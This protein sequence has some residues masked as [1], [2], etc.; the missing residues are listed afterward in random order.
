LS[1]LRVLIANEAGGGRGHVTMLG[2]AAR[3][4]GNSVDCVAA[5]ADRT[6]AGEVGDCCQQ[7]LRA[8]ALRMLPEVWANP[9]LE[10]NAGWGDYLAACGLVRPDVVRHSL[11]WWRKTIVAQDISVLVA[12]YAP[13]AMRAAQGL[14]ADGWQMQ[15]VALGTGYG[16][17][18]AQLERFP[19]LMP[20]YSRVVHPEAETLA[21][22]NQVGA[23]TGLDPLP[24]LPAIC[25][26]D[27]TL[28]CTF[29]FLDPYAALRSAG[30][31]FQPLQSV[32]ELASSGDELFVYMSG[33]NLVQ[34]PGLL[35]ALEIL[36]MPRRGYLPG[37]ESAVVA[38]L[39]ASGMVIEPAAVTS[40]AIARRSRVVLHTAPHGTLCMAML[41][42]LPQVGLPRNLEQ[43]F[44]G[45]RVAER[46]VL[47]LL[48]GPDVGTEAIIDAVMQSASGEAPRR[49]ARDLA[50]QLR[51]QVASDTVAALADRLRPVLA[52]AAAT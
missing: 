48:H 19:V 51:P 43:V 12:D 45:R 47:R 35:R 37:A 36:P 50:M 1:R 18:P 31:V 4:F 15:I 8:P 21:V 13:L 28:A 16:V 6:H 52:R 2:V 42:G 24:R 30:E 33:R 3:A 14:Q 26:A 38:R 23:E 41:A 7:V 32:P 10:G 29:D 49:A 39:A 5:L 44:H 46:G 34:T 25:Q 22:V 40:E 9:T 27:L 11:E 20:E 17:P